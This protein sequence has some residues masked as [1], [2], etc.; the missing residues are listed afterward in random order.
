MPL[1]SSTPRP[2]PGDDG[3]RSPTP[4]AS[5]R[6]R[7][8]ALARA[9]RRRRRSAPATCPPS[10]RRST[11]F[12]AGLGARRPRARCTRCC[13]DDAKPAHV[14]S[15]GCERTYEQAAETLTLERVRAGPVDRRRHG[16][17]S[18]LETRIF[19][20]LRGHARR[21]RPASART[22][23]RASTGAPSSSTP[24]C[25]AAR[26]CGAR[27][28][29]PPRATIQ[30]RDGTADRQ[31]PGPRVRPR[32]DR[33]RDRR[34]HRPRAAGARRPSSRRAACPTGAAGR[35]DRPRARVRRAALTGTPGG[36]LFAGD[37][38]AG[39]PQA[40]ARPRR[41]H[42]DRPEDPARRGRGAR[43]PLRRDR[44]RAP[45]QRRGAGAGRDRPVGARSRPARPS[46]SSRS[47]ACWRTRSP[48]A[49]DATR[50]RTRPTIEGVEIQ[51]ANGESCGG[52]LRDLLRALL[53]P[54][55][56]A[57]GR[58]ARRGEARRDAPRSSA[59]TRTRRS[60]ARRARRSPPR[61]RSA[62][63]SRSARRAIGQ[64]KVLAT[65][66][67]MALVG[68]HDRRRR[69]APA[70][71]RCSRAPTRSA[72]ARRAPSVART[73]KSY[74]RTV[75]DRRHRRRRP[76]SRRQGRGQDRH[77][78][79]AH[80][81]QGGAAAGGHRPRRSRR[82]RTTRP[83]PTPGSSR[84]RPTRKPTIAV[85]VMLV[86]QGAGGD[87]AAPAAGAGPQGR[88]ARLEV[89]VDLGRLV[90]RLLDLEPSGRFCSESVLSRK[91]ISE[92]WIGPLAAAR[93]RRRQHLRVAAAGSGRRRTGSSS[94]P[95]G[96]ARNSFPSVSTIV[97][98]SRRRQRLV[99]VVLDPH[100]DAEPDLVAGQLR[101]TSVGQAHQ[102]LAGPRRRPGSGS[103]RAGPGSRG[104]RRRRRCPRSR[105]S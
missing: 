23:T 62:T 11:A 64:G 36:I 76:R 88:A 81:G 3:T 28:R 12:A 42:D 26:S 50:S 102:V 75:V 32:T 47:P 77:R 37:A 21:S 14:A 86:G 13:R 18:S 8:P 90:A 79:A 57:A 35:P 105:P 72:C 59:S 94:R 39:Q 51:N 80:D 55:L 89:E 7:R 95:A 61:P 103:A 100:P 91:R 71:R 101:L 92:P 20:T 54:R 104:R 85:A 93:V 19:G 49:R 65:P 56:R 31:G 41:A 87:T 48:S 66:L 97:N 6:S 83:T 17:R 43:G 33:L 73:I 84:S 60:P 98:S 99:R 1:T 58:Q 68:G 22:P 29:C 10:A 78:R 9:G 63:T 27:P 34:A 44:G 24:A 69:R 16:R 5:P 15:S 45:E 82:R 2:R 4:A 46:R 25:A 38:R 96:S 53:Q 30:A 70:R 40:Q 52:S 67:Q 74:M